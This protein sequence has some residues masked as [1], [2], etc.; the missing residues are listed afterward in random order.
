MIGRT[1]G[2]YQ[3][4]RKLGAGGNGEVYQA[5]D[6]EVGRDVALKT[7]HPQLG[8]DARARER[9]RS[10][11]AN[12][13]RLNHPNITTL[14]TIV[15]DESA[16]CMVMELLHGRELTDVIEQVG[17]LTVPEALAVIG[18]FGTGLT[19]A[20]RAGIIHRDIKPS[21]V[22]LQDDGLLKIMDF[23]IARAQ[24]AKRLTA[25]GT[26]VGTLDYMSPE[27]VQGGQGD[28]RSD[29]YSLAILL[30]ELL[31]GQP[32]FVS[33]SDYNLQR[34][35]LELKPPR[36]INTV[37]GLPAAVDAALAKALA[38]KP[39]DRFA[40]V[41]DFCMAL[42]APS[43]QVEATETLR[44]LVVRAYS[45]RSA[46]PAPPPIIR[47]IRDPVRWRR[48]LGLGGIGT[49]A[50]A[51]AG[52]TGLFNPPDTP[53]TPQPAPITS[54]S[55]LP[56]PRP[57]SST[58]EIKKQPEQA[59]LVPAPPPMPQIELPQV[60]PPAL[61]GRLS[62]MI[63]GATLNIG[64]RQVVPLAGIASQGDPD[65]PQIRNLTEGL[66]GKIRAMNAP[67]NCYSQGIKMFRCEVGGRDVAILSLETGLSTAAADAPSTYVEAER[68]AKSQRLGVWQKL[69]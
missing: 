55:P 45:T 13:G 66:I 1:I 15:R 5:R 19:Y 37:P 50:L 35:H 30:Y 10:E 41:A 22:M 12:L 42:G 65:S 16:Q 62:A 52:V 61:S 46:T 47:V 36:L 14:Y 29:I 21:N 25:D 39:T 60:T 67:L 49:L 7:L 23:G 32:P 40:S 17:R 68:R 2:H 48:W 69:R 44:Q 6:L 58:P 43:N 18:Q 51:V 4:T 54:G 9:F 38:K 31:S 27:Q 8:S 33:N 63:D 64:N 20:H 11:A 3:I 53:P 28:E 56:E 57:Q 24:G 34:A 26:A 59:V